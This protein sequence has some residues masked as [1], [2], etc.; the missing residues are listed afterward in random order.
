MNVREEYDHECPA[1][2]GTQTEL[3]L[4]SKSNV[5]CTFCNKGKVTESQYNGYVNNY[6]IHAVSD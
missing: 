1:C 6:I 5:K 4:F 3:S 2:L